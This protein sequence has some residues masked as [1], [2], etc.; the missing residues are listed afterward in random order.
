MTQLFD[1]LSHSD[2]PE[3]AISVRDVSKMYPLYTRPSDRLRQSVYYALPYFLRGEPRSF[4]REFWALQDISFDVRQGETLGIIGMNGSGKSTL[5]Q[6]IAGT[7]APTTGEV[8][9]RGRVAALLELGSGFNME[10]TGRENVY[11]AGA[12][13]GLSREEMAERFDEIAAFANIGEFIDQPVKL[14]S[15]GMYVRLAFAVQTCIEPEILI[16]DEIL[17]VGDIFFQ[18]KC[19][20]RL[21]EMLANKTAVVMVSHDMA[22]IEKY[23]SQ[24]ILLD[25]GHCQFQGQP[26]EA[27]QRFYLLENARRRQAARL[28][29]AAG[30]SNGAY[31]SDIPDWPEADAFLPLNEAS[32]L[33][34]EGARCLGIALCDQSGQSRQIFGI[35]ETAVFYYE[36]EL[37][38]DIGVPVGGVTLTNIMNVTV[39]GKNSAQALLS[40]PDVV[41][42][43]G[44][45][46]FRQAIQLSLGQG[47]YTF[48]VGFSTIDAADYARFAEM[49][50]A[51]FHERA[52]VLALVQNAG[53]F[54]MVTR[55]AGPD[56]PFHGIADMENSFKVAIALGEQA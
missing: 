56:I 47:Q 50:Y 16:V 17:S 3:V 52:L 37:T 12:I 29:A 55:A 1:Q 10:F 46:R 6:I 41:P 45:V 22:S 51:V 39:H 31:S 28:P 49:P 53:A 13:L 14:Y 35:G 20:A 21:D 32:I 8:R 42:E 48:S 54:Q 33:S 36:F 4:F 19:F 11:L 30:G 24:T 2:D 27:V 40:A 15:S 9:L 7:L 18:Q 23:S 34:G 5:L 43:G 44:R 38:Q 26:N 25:K